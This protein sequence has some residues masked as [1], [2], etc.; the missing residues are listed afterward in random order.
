MAVDSSGNVYV[1]DQNNHRIRKISP[2]GVV[3]TFAG[4]S[5]GDDGRRS[6][7][8][9]SLIILLAWLSIA[10]EMSMWRIWLTII[11][12]ARSLARARA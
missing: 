10:V 12:F 9:L 5:Q 3:T 4:S 2:A 7:L 6:L 1:A 11:V 8:M